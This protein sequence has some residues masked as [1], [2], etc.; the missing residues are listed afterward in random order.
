MARI[1]F[2]V[3]R[4]GDGGAERQ[5]VVLAKELATLGHT[6][7]IATWVQGGNYAKDLVGSGV[8]TER[9]YWPIPGVGMATLIATGQALVR[10]FRPHVIH[11]YMDQANMLV[12][13]LRSP[14][15]G[16]RIVW[17]IRASALERHHYDLYSR[18]VWQLNRLLSRRADLVISNSRSGAEHVAAHHYERSR[19]KVIANGIDTRRFYYDADGGAQLR[20]EWGTREGERVI[21]MAA[22][23]DPMKG[24]DTFVAAARLLSSRH[25]NVR[26]VCA[27]EGLEPWRSDVLR[28]VNSAGLGE[29]FQWVG[30]I[31]EIHSF[32]SALDLATST[33]SFGEGFS[34]AVAEA[35]ACGVSCV[36]TDVG[37][38]ALIVGDTGRVVPPRD[39]GALAHAW[40]QALADPRRPPRADCRAR[41]VAQFSLARLVAETEAA[42]LPA[43]V[44]RLAEPVAA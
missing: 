9:L 23:L 13:F 34:N 15:P 3:W 41:V 32:Y 40:E 8:E 29:R 6:V 17:G 28:E 43:G 24:Y 22:R 37:D 18:L 14:E 5:L 31:S 1:L 4:L 7:K 35:M 2:L 12:A 16:C 44:P 30:Q 26:F 10:R 19:V 38:S 39:P 27:G 20:R 11:G 21:G 33:S 36:V 42:I 25:R